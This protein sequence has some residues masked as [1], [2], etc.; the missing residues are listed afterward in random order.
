MRAGHDGCS[1]CGVYTTPFSQ[2]PAL[3]LRRAV[4]AAVQTRWGRQLRSAR[5]P[6]R[7]T[8]LRAARVRDRPAVLQ[9]VRDQLQDRLLA[10]G[11][12]VRVLAEPRWGVRAGRRGGAELLAVD[13][14]DRAGVGDDERR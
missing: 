13:R 7:V 9:E 8:R 11:A 10:A 4:I 6:V 5:E 3:N 1:D 14:A 2:H 12:A